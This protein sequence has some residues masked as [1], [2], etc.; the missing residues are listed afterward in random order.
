M[1]ILVYSVAPLPLL[2]YMAEYLARAGHEVITLTGKQSHSLPGTRRIILNFACGPWKGKES[3]EIWKEVIKNAVFGRKALLNLAANWQPDL[4]LARSGQG[5]AFFLREVFPK[6]F[7]ASFAADHER[8]GIEVDLDSRLFLESQL[9]FARNRSGIRLF[10]QALRKMI[11]PE[12]LFVD[13][14]FFG[15]DS[16]EPFRCWKFD[17]ER[18]RLVAPVLK[19]L[20]G[21]DLANWARG[22]AIALANKPDLGLVTLM[23]K[24]EQ[25]QRLLDA[26]H[27]LPGNLADRLFITSRLDRASWRN[28]C[29]CSAAVIFTCAGQELLA[30]ECA[31]T[32]R[33]PYAAKKAGFERLPGVITMSGREPLETRLTSLGP[34]AVS[35]EA[36]QKLRDE[37]GLERVVPAFAE[38]ILAEA[39]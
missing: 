8:P 28:L 25:A 4:I 29:L 27:C 22:M 6:T 5:A 16:H 19:G 33:A 35:R 3:A 21:P 38:R 10:P 39:G 30:L 7:V 23:D 37:Y 15:G 13:T 34:A 11:R 31:A 17:S 14:D 36:L 24:A 1:R 12:P 32:G 18:L 26:M 2:N 20:H 9:A